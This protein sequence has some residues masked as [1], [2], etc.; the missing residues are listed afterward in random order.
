MNSG[1]NK[2][3]NIILR[4]TYDFALEIIKLYKLLSESKKEYVLSK[5]ILRSG[6]SVGANIN[7]AISAESK[8]DF[9]HK[10]GISLK[11]ARETLYW[12]NLLKDSSYLSQDHFKKLEILNNEIISIITKI[13]KTSKTNIK[14]N[15]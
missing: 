12:L 15:S 5:Q 6:T 8:S 1:N 3:D 4:K 13:I 9:I 7:E 14:N 2:S 10:F 11:E